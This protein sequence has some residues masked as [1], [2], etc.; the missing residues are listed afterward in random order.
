MRP[1]RSADALH[2]VVEGI[3]DAVFWNEL[4]ASDR[5]VLGA[6]HSIQSGTRDPLWN[7]RSK[8]LPKQVYV[9]AGVRLAMDR[10]RDIVDVPRLKVALR[11]FFIR[12]ALLLLARCA[13]LLKR[14]YYDR[15]L[16]GYK[17]ERSSSGTETEPLTAFPA[18]MLYLTAER[19]AANEVGGLAHCSFKWRAESVRQDHPNGLSRQGM[20]ATVELC[21][22]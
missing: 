8:V 14:I 12:L 11:S 5:C 10:T 4:S 18:R 21:G 9:F 22:G 19:R 3:R 15:T 7:I 20:Q 2:E 17:S 13:Q 1:I 16:R 6:R